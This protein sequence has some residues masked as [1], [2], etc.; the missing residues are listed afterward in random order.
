MRNDDKINYGELIKNLR[1]QNS[2]TQTEL[3]NMVSLGKTAISNYETGY[4]V[5]SLSVIESIAAV[6][7]LTIVDFLSGNTCQNHN[8]N[9][10][11][12]RQ[13]ASDLAIPYIK[14]EN[15][16]DSTIEAQNYMDATLVLPSFMT[17]FKDGY[18]CVKMND[19]SMKADN[20]SKNDY[21]I[22]K[23]SDTA[24]PRQ[25]VLVLDNENGRYMIRRYIREGHIASLIPSSDSTDYP[26]V[27]IDERDSKFVIK[28][29]VERV[30]SKLDY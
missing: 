27:R 13:S 8:F 14:V 20:I 1:I 2:M 18:I 22:I 29:Y 17:D 21:L 23:K 3:G 12:Y 15:V 28:G 16:K 10:P 11:R 24:N 30:I 9:M 6:F 5:P 25:I 7:G 4:I 26:V 19:D